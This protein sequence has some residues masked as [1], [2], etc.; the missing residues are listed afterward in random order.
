M[1]N[2]F[3][4]TTPVVLGIA[5]NAGQDHRQS[6]HGF[7]AMP[8]MRRLTSGQTYG[9]SPC[10]RNSLAQNRDIDAEDSRPQED[11]ERH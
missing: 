2:S 9:Y 4:A 8:K 11:N 3:V 6:T 5:G 7:V 10:L 1:F